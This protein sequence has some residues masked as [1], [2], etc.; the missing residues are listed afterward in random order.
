MEDFVDDSVQE[1]RSC[2][3]V[4]NTDDSPSPIQIRIGEAYIR[5]VLFYEGGY[6]V[7]DRIRRSGPEQGSVDA[8]LILTLEEEEEA[9][10]PVPY[11]DVSCPHYIISAQ[12]MGI[13]LPLQSA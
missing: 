5:C 7:E 1:L 8:V 12:I 9:Y 6:F 11:C 2:F 13:P 3:G 10:A 4:A